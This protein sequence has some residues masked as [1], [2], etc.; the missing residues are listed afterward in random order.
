MI[1]MAPSLADVAT[2]ISPPAFTSHRNLDPAER[3]SQGITDAMVRLSCGVEAA[4]DII[5]DL[6]QGLLAVA[7]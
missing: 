1:R 2:A 5:A 3:A 7:T 6:E 4:A